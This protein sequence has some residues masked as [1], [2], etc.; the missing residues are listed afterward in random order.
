MGIVLNW[1][2]VYTPVLG[3]S[4]DSFP[5]VTDGT[6]D[7]MASHVNS[8]ATSLVAVETLQQSLA[9]T[10]AGLGVTDRIEDADGDTY[11]DTDLA[12]GDS[13]VLTLAAPNGIVLASTL[14]R[15][16]L[17]L[18]IASGLTPAADT[19][20]G[21]GITITT[22]V[23]GDDDGVSGA[24]RGGS[25]AVT[26]GTGGAGAGILGG[27]GGGI[28]FDAGSGAQDSSGGSNGDGGSIT[29]NAG[30]GAN[31]TVTAGGGDGGQGYF[32]GG[33]GGNGTGSSPP[34]DGGP[35]I[36]LGGDAGTV[37]S[38]GAPDGGNVSIRGGLG[39]G[40]SGFGGT[41]SLD[42]GDST[43]TFGD[44]TIG[45]LETTNNIT[46]LAQADI[47]FQANGASAAIP[48]NEVGDTDLDGSFTATSIV[49]ALN[50]LKT[51]SSLVTLTR[52]QRAVL[53]GDDSATTDVVQGLVGLSIFGG[54]TGRATSPASA[55][56]LERQIRTSNQSATV[57]NSTAGKRT[58]RIFSLG[59]STRAQAVVGFLGSGIADMRVMVGFVDS[60]SAML[61]GGQ[62]PSAS[63]VP[64]GVFL[65]LDSTDANLQ[66]MHKDTGI[67]AT[68]INLGADFA[69]AANMTV[70]LT[71]TTAP[72]QVEYSV[73]RLDAAGSASGVINTNVPADSAL[74]AWYWMSACST[75]STASAID[76]VALTLDTT[77]E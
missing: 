33:T 42:G 59:V 9:S 29:L 61:T 75:A 57:V 26:C 44:V 31:A 15:S 37:L 22:G 2:S 12:G 30:P 68:K 34:G 21:Y 47:T 24:G 10:V 73:E 66:I 74:L 25:F 77:I 41:V 64:A 49:G 38:A 4:I 55:V 13:D 71:L 65:A 43:G 67:A 6:H 63:A 69:R 23:G 51:N 72:G 5:T 76:T 36:I 11:A 19:V 14:F 52:T 1:T 35:V 46:A 62:Q 58:S 50:E 45:A 32:S 27:D 16:N 20:N 17:A 56:F 18:S 8:L 48:F 39:R 40:F 7:V 54:A 60:A 53:P 70:R 3:S 28:L